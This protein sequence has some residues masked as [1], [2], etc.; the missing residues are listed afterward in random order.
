MLV[1]ITLLLETTESQMTSTA[2]PHYELR[3]FLHY[4]IYLTYRS[5]SSRV[6][7]SNF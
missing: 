2:K 4:P 1:N 3:T 6:S 5:V 7:V